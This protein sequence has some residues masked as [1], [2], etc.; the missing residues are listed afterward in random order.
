MSKFALGWLPD[1]P[2]YRDYLATSNEGKKYIAE[3][4]RNLKIK[5][6]ALKGNPVDLRPF[7][8]PIEDQEGIGSCTAQAGVGLVEYI[9][10]NQFQEYLDASRLFLYKVTRNLLG[11]TGDTGAYVRTTFKALRLFGTVPESYYPYLTPQYDN[12]PS[13]FCYSFARNY[14]ILRYLKLKDLTEVKGILDSGLPVAFGFTVFRSIF[15]PEVEE[16]GVI[17]VPTQNDSVA[18]G[19]AVA[20]VGYDDKKRYI[21]IRNSWGERWGDR[22]YGYLPY[23]YFEKGLCR[24]FWV[25]VKTKYESLRH[26]F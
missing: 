7:C 10:L 22:G 17:K 8:T 12:E 16:T 21:I 19:H 5:Q 23:Q 1:Y 2:D 26:A 14:Q 3:T 6:S 4:S 25:L 15:L 20:A 9:E 24:D 11:L 13:P 18:G